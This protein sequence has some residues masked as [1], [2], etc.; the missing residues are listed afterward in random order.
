MC[1]KRILEAIYEQDFLA[2][3][4]GYRP[5]TGALKAVRDLTVKLQFGRYTR[6]VDADI[7]GYFESIDH[8]WMRRMLEERIEDGA[9][10][11]LID[12]WMKAGI[13]EEDG[14]VMHPAAGTPQ[15]VGKKGDIGNF[16]T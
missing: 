13:L 11:R 1:V 14:Q 6:V 10:L 9:L 4:Y 7:Q 5:G 8:S 15:G 3:S 2:C 12:K 16:V